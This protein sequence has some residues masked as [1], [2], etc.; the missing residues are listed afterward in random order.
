MIYYHPQNILNWNFPSQIRYII[1]KTSFEIIDSWESLMVSENVSK[2]VQCAYWWPGTVPCWRCTRTLI[3]E[4]R[5]GGYWSNFFHFVVIPVF[6]NFRNI[7]YIYNIMF[8]FDRCH[9]SWAAVTPAKYAHDLKC[10][11]YTFAKWKFSVMETLTNKRPVGLSSFVNCP[12]VVAS[13]L[14]QRQLSINAGWQHM[15]RVPHPNYVDPECC[16]ASRFASCTG[17]IWV[18]FK[19]PYLI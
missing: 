10:L 16:V 3:I 4:F 2:F 13:F 18:T 1:N 6:L 19:E 5:G 7:G 17:S 9:C 14:T 8:I 11:T 12:P 15:G